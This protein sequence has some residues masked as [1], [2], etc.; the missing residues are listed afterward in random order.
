MRHPVA[1]A[2][3]LAAL[4]LSAVPVGFAAPGVEVQVAGYVDDADGS[5]FD[6]AAR[7]RP[8]DWLSLS[9]G[10][11]QSSVSLV[12]SDFQGRSVRGGVDL[13][14]GRFGAGLRASSWEDSDQFSS[15]ILEAELS[16][17]FADTLDV[18]LRLED[19]R[20]EVDYATVGA[21]GRVLPQTARFDGTGVGARLAWYGREWSAWIDGTSYDYDARLERLVAASR[22]PS[23]R[24]FPQLAVLI[25]SV[26]TRTAGAIDYQASVG[27]ERSF[28]RAWVG[29]DLLR[30]RDS[31]SGADSTSL[32]LS[33][34]Y[35]L[36]ARWGVDAQLGTIDTE[37]IDRTGFAGLGFSFR[38]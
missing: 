9:I 30:S 20:L 1:P 25:N 6:V 16:W 34:R 3:L 26:L 17:T 36:S 29:V 15:D 10:G 21:F 11:G 31:V 24:A 27:V 18:A 5:S 23:T 28:A 33:F 38:N 22:A 19:R 14:R 12:A 35:D 13:R 2:A 7:L 4:S 8:V 37:G 32:G